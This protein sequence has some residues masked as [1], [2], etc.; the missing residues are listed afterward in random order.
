MAEKMMVFCDFDGTI[1]EEETLEHFIEE[2]LQI[3]VKQLSE[4]MV[5]KG[6]T[7]KRGIKEQMERI[8]SQTYKSV[9]HR[10]GRRKIREGFVEFLR[11]MQHLEVPV[12]VVSG[13]L[14]EM[15]MDSL[16][17]YKDMIAAIYH[18]KADLSQEYVHYYSEYESEE[19]LVSKVTIMRKYDVQTT[20]CIGDSYT[21]KI[22]AVHSDIV[23]ARDRLAKAMRECDKS[24]YEFDTFFDIIEI[25][26]NYRR[27]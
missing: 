27:N 1:T 15:V 3:D 2:C 16:S 19:E 23:F 5:K 25:M 22:M 13:G 12:V 9:L 20:I 8:P 21:D 10:T 11:Y 17:D 18:A 4:E 24:Y 7:V 26:E 6:Y 14:E